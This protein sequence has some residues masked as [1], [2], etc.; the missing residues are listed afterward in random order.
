MAF[1]GIKGR[2]VA[3]KLGVT[4]NW[5]YIVINGHRK[6]PRVQKAIA[7]ML[8]MKVRELWPED[9]EEAA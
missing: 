6:S 1:K 8:G 7:D 5:V 4:D 3:R 9:E 2:D